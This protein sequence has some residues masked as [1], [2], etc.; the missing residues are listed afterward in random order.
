[1][2][3]TSENGDAT[4]PGDEQQEDQSSE[5]HA[6]VDSGAV[7]QLRVDLLNTFKLAYQADLPEDE[8]DDAVDY[9]RDAAREDWG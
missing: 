2:T 4:L 7:D 9:A 5:R 1:M 6:D 8:I 3:E